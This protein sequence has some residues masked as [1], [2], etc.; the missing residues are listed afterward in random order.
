MIPLYLILAGLVGCVVV[1]IY[2]W[3]TDPYWFVIPLVGFVY[4]S[5]MLVAAELAWV[6]YWAICFIRK[7]RKRVLTR[8]NT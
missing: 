3:H 4:L 8:K 2:R 5:L 1:S 6:V 7:I